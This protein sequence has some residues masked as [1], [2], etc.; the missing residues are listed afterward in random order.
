MGVV[1]YRFRPDNW[2]TYFEEL[3]TMRAVAVECFSAFRN[4][5]QLLLDGK[6]PEFFA[7]NPKWKELIGYADKRLAFPRSAVDE[8]GYTQ[9]TT[10]QPTQSELLESSQTAYA[11]SRW[12]SLRRYWKLKDAVGGYCSALDNFTRQLDDD[13]SVL[14]ALLK[15]QDLQTRR[16]VMADQPGRALKATAHQGL[17]LCSAITEL[18]RTLSTVTRM[19]GQHSNQFDATESAVTTAAVDLWCYLLTMAEKPSTKQKGEKPFG[20]ALQ[21]TTNR[22]KNELLR[23]KKRGI[24][25]SIISEEILWDGK[26]GLWIAIDVDHPLATLT[27]LPEVWERLRDALAPDRD[28]PLQHGIITNGWQD[29][30]VVPLVGGRSL[31]RQAHRH[32]KGTMF[33]NNSLEENPWMLTAEPVPDDVWRQTKVACWEHNPRTDTMNHVVDTYAATFAHVDHIADFTRLP[34]EFDDLGEE[35]IKAHIRRCE[36][37]GDPK[38]QEAFNAYNAVRRIADDESDIEQ[39]PNLLAW[40]EFIEQADDALR[41]PMQPDQTEHRLTLE[42]LATWRDQ[43]L[44]GIGNL[45]IAKMLW[46]ADCYGF[47]AYEHPDQTTER[48]AQSNKG[49]TESTDPD[50]TGEDNELLILMEQFNDELTTVGEISERI[51][52]AIEE[53]GERMGSRAE[54]IERLTSS[55]SASRNAHKRVFARTAADMNK[56]AQ[57]IGTELPLF[58]EHL[59]KGVCSVTQASEIASELDVVEDSLLEV[60]REVKSTLSTVEGRIAGLMHKVSSIPRATT[61][62]NRAKR[63]LTDVLHQLCNEINRGQMITQE[64]DRFRPSVSAKE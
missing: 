61:V 12:I 7:E 16:N 24:N 43:L 17:A 39:R 40:D 51:G 64:A 28:K 9:E 37:R 57:R 58:A 62:L 63:S 50:N 35:I 20:W 21:T 31:A 23:L 55:Q 18:Q 6:K 19:Q 32:F 10:R 30:V 8:W 53:I 1:E 45:G 13:F 14:C 52:A 34:E 11:R 56:C 25:C 27:A 38:L 47:P 29:I 4:S 59:N 5:L 46:I 3:A 22:I 60:I 41:A 36:Q 49:D 54:E 44:E 15:I 26:R 2:T 48:L 33:L 42:Q